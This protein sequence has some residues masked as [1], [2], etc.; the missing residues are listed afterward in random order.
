MNNKL[1]CAVAENCDAEENEVAYQLELIG[2]YCE[3]LKGMTWD[4]IVTFF[5]CLT[6]KKAGYINIIPTDN[7]LIPE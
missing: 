6:V 4:E 2:E 3:R 5:A 7:S 1:L